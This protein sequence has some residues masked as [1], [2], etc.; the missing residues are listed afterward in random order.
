[1]L[2]PGRYVGLPEEEETQDF[3]ERFTSLK[4]KFEEQIKEEVVLNKRISLI[5]EKIDYEK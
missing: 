4:S 1:M 3:T 2:A 5:L